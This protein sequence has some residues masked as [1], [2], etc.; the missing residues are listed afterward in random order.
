ML[1]WDTPVILFFFFKPT[2]VL[3]E[4]EHWEQKIDLL[5]S[6]KEN[7][8]Q[9]IAPIWEMQV[10]PFTKVDHPIGIWSIRCACEHEIRSEMAGQRLGDSASL[11]VHK[12]LKIEV[13]PSPPQKKGKRRCLLPIVKSQNLIDRVINRVGAFEFYKKVPA[14]V[15][16]NEWK[17]KGTEIY[18]AMCNQK[19]TR[20][21]TIYFKKELKTFDSQLSPRYC[22]LVQLTNRLNVG[23]IK[24]VCR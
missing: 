13:V 12:W 4:S 10:D 17:N 24:V 18:I 22:H 15:Q 8:W 14:K 11:Y 6:Q 1:T 9:E 19:R 7:A 2:K 3:V 16:R 5:L 21:D 20:G 23:D